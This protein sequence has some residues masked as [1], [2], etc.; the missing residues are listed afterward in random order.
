MME[1]QRRQVQ[2][3]NQQLRERGLQVDWQ[4]EMLESR[5]PDGRAM[6]VPINQWNVRSIG[7]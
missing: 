7:Q 6:I 5:L 2:A 1:Q 4:P 3:W